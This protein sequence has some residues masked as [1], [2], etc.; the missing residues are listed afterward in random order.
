M[1]CRL[2]TGLALLGAGSTLM[3][4]DR[5]DEGGRQLRQ[6]V[7]HWRRAGN[8]TLQR[9]T[10]HYIAELLARFDQTDLTRRILATADSDNRAP[11]VASAQAE[12]LAN[13]QSRLGDPDHPPETLDE[14]GQEAVRALERRGQRL[15]L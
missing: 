14:I 9:T 15:E 8:I 3:K 7:L 10:L 4:L 5:L 12:R 11:P 13:L 1:S 2:V 6:S